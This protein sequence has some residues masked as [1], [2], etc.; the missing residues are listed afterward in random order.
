MPSMAAI[1]RS[2]PALPGLD[3]HYQVISPSTCLSIRH[4]LKRFAR[5]LVDTPRTPFGG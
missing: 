1:F 3:L 2:V 5:L 4:A